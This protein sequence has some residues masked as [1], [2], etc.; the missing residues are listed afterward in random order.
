MRR[1]GLWFLVILALSAGVSPAGPPS[2]PKQAEKSLKEGLRLEEANQWKDAEAAYSEAIQS[3]PNSAAAF[4]HRARVRYFNG[5][6]PHAQEDAGSATRL[7][8]NNGAA[9]QLLGDIDQRVKNSRKAVTDYTRAVELGVNS[10]EV[11]NSRA[12]AH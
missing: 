2:N 12:V 1:R 11:Y 8:P 6:Y 3:D 4:F 9:F 10:A 5:D 7:E